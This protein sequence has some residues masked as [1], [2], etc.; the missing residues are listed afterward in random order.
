MKLWKECYRKQYWERVKTRLIF[1]EIASE[2]SKLDDQ[3]IDY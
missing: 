3:P 1:P 2:R